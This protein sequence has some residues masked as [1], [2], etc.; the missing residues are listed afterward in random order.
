MYSYTITYS[1]NHPELVGKTILELPAMYLQTLLN[2]NVTSD[3]PNVS[4]NLVQDQVR[5]VLSL[6][7]R[8]Y[9]SRVAF[10]S[11]EGY[12]AYSSA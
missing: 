1:K 8:E 7:Q 9:L 3:N 4:V 12:S 10:G 5:I 11:S 6:K 2:G